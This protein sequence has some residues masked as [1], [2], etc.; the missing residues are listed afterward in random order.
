MACIA[1]FARGNFEAPL[2]QFPGKKAFIN[3]NIEHLRANLKALIADANM[4]VKAA[5]EGKLSTRADA[6]EAW[7]R[8]PQDRGGRE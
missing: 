7:R 5:V 8:L 1:E 4:L 3:D 6:S 2:E